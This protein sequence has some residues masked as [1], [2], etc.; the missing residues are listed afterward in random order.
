L[1]ASVVAVSVDTSMPMNALTAR[2]AL[3]TLRRGPGE[4]VLL[5]DRLSTAIVEQF[6]AAVGAIDPDR[7]LRVG[8]RPG[9]EPTARL[10]IGRSEE[11]GAVRIVPDG[12]GAHVAGMRSAVISPAR[13]GNALGAVYAA[14][15]GA[16]EV[17]KHAAGVLP[18]RR[19]LHRHLRFCPVTLSED[20]RVVPDL[21][22]ALTLHLALIG[23]GAIGTG[24]ALILGELGAEG[25]MLAVDRQRFA[26]E[27][28]GTYSLGGADDV[29]S[30]PWK[31]DLARRAVPK[32][33]VTPYCE[34]VDKLP[35]AIDS[36]EL[37]WYR[38]ALT[39]LD[40][41]GARRE[42]QRLWPDRLIDGA[43]GD[44]M[45]G[46][47]DYGYGHDPCMICVFPVRRDG[48]S[49]VDRLAEL[50]GLPGDL[51]GQGDKLLAEEH[52]VGLTHEQ[53]QLL[54]PHV[55]KP[56]CGLARAAGL[57]GVEAAGFMPAVPFV[58]LQA[59]CLSVGRLLAHRLGLDPLTNLVQYDGLF[60]PQAATMERMTPRP[61]CY[62]QTRTRTISA[63]RA[64]R[65]ALLAAKIALPAKYQRD[66]V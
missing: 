9:Q 23:V 8:R 39:G 21:P 20:L 62:C 5:R 54:E 26:R 12:Y 45:V 32:F 59:A 11:R 17:F 15:L 1:D 27:N 22:E 36:G 7:P 66:H 60:G 16:A 44:T 25:T 14:A 28:R 30:A 10:H 63:V 18:T 50:T 46:L 19:V 51:L 35:A 3:T 61:D 41:P 13:P 33:D 52:L 43:T 47:H 53:R 49:A 34:P 58:S 2:V 40:S 56:V 6:E 57:T 31:V 29:T 65:T 37:P 24:I 55:G 38:L 42:A 64:K 48:P 4:L